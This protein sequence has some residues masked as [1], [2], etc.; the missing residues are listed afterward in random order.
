MFAATIR[1]HHPRRPGLH[2]PPNRHQLAFHAPGP[3]LLAARQIR[4]R[5]VGHDRPGMVLVLQKSR[6]LDQ[7]HHQL[8]LQHRAQDRHDI[9]VLRVDGRVSFIDDGH[10]HHRNESIVQQQPQQVA[11]HR[12]RFARKITLDERLAVLTH[13][14]PLVTHAP[15]Q[16]A[17]QPGEP[18][19]VDTLRLKRLHDALV[20]ESRVRHE[21]DVDQLLV[22]VD[23]RVAGD[24]G[25]NAFFDA[26][27]LGQPVPQRVGAVHDHL[28]P[29]DQGQVARN[30]VE[31][32]CVAAADLD[33]QHMSASFR[34]NQ[35]YQ[36]V[37]TV[38]FGTG[39]H[40]GAPR[41]L[42]G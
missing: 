20:P 12:D 31:V 21:H 8:G 37:A 18:D 16:G 28:R 30:P 38:P 4:T 36:K 24:R 34:K 25:E 42:P 2:Q 13:A 26:Q 9:V 35:S 14:D 39:V 7:L 17:V 27:P 23:A 22:G 15:H 10:R 5:D 41:A 11:V 3:L 32:D 29:S 33:Y 6:R 1:D 19:R 40:A